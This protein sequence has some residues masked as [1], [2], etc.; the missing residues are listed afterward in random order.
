MSLASYREAPGEQL[1][2]WSPACGFCGL[3]GEP[4]SPGKSARGAARPSSVRARRPRPSRTIRP[5]TTSAVTI[6]PVTPARCQS[7]PVPTQIA[8]ERDD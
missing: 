5:R 6:S 8:E 7:V 4:H 3:K 1:G 2:A